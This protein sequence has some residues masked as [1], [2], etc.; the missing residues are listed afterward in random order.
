MSA[1]VAA[2]KQAPQGVDFV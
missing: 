1:R 2:T